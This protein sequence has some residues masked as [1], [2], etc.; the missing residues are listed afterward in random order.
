M[1]CIALTAFLN[2]PSLTEPFTL[3][4]RLVVPFFLLAE[5]FALFTYFLAAVSKFTSFTTVFFAFFLA[6]TVVAVAAVTVIAKAVA[7]ITAFIPDFLIVV[8]S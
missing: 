3:T 4:F 8:T 1:Q 5:A 2:F 6:V 7:I